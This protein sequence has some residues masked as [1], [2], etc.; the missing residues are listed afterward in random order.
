LLHLM[1][2]RRRPNVFLGIIPV[3]ADRRGV[4]PE[5]AF[6][7]TD[8]QLVTVELVSGYLS[9]TRPDEVALYAAMWERL[10]TLAA[11]GTTATALIRSALNRLEAGQEGV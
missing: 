2:L 4:H 6:N 1:K 10:W 8:D 9:V 5:E 7:I 11:T 3:D